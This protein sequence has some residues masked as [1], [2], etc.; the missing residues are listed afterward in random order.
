MPGIGSTVII[1]SGTNEPT[2]SATTTLADLLIDSGTF[3]QDGALTLSGNYAQAGGTYN[4][5][6]NLSIGAISPKVA[7]LLFQTPP[8]PLQWAIVFH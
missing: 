5:N 6:A 8:R 3:T 2:L 7:G 4:Q 1:A